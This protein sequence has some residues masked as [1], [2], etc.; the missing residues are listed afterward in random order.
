[1]YKEIIDKKIEQL[2]KGIIKVNTTY[3]SFMIENKFTLNLSEDIYEI[4][5]LK[6]NE[7]NKWE[8]DSNL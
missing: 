1:M 8:L 5:T 3:Y 6:K 7:Y 4:I 2:N